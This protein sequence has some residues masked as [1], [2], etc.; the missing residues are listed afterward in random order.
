[1]A[2]HDVVVFD[3]DDKPVP[4]L[5][6]MVRPTKPNIIQIQMRALDEYEMYEAPDVMMECS[7]HELFAT[8]LKMKIRTALS[9]IHGIRRGPDLQYETDTLCERAMSLMSNY[10]IANVDL[11]NRTVVKVVPELDVPNEARPPS[12]RKQ[13]A[14]L[15]GRLVR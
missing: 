13:F 12:L 6:S 7:D 1:M 10:K 9:K 11:V 15:I 3:P 4:T 2:R 14:G 8:R 5:E